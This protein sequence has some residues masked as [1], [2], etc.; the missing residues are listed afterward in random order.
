MRK[1]I[2]HEDFRRLMNGTV[3]G[4]DVTHWQYWFDSLEPHQKA[5]MAFIFSVCVG[6]TANKKEPA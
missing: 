2:A 3:Y 1:P 4:A 6:V 5:R